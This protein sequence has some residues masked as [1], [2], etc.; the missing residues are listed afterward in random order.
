MLKTLKG[1]SIIF[2][3]EQVVE[4][5]EMRLK[6]VAVADPLTAMAIW[7]STVLMEIFSRAATSAY[8]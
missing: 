3:R 5:G 6:I 8:F 2:F 7:A 4:F 1:G